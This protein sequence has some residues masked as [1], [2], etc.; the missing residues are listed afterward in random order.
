MTSSGVPQGDEKGL[1]QEGIWESAPSADSTSPASSRAGGAGTGITQRLTSTERVPGPGG[2][3][4]AD[5][6][7]RIMALILDIIALSL[8]GFLLSWLFGGLVSEPGAINEA[9]GQLDVAAFLL[10]LL[11]QLLVS[12]AYF[13]SLWTMAGATLGMRLLGLHIGDEADGHSISWRQSAIRWLI[14]GLP[15][16]LASTA[17]Y[18]PNTIGL[19][20][21]AVGVAWLLLLLY[22]MIQSPAKQGLHDRYAHTIVTRARRHAS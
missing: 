4:Y 11:L 2:L 5:V 18:V 22:T 14:L 15:A 9:G 7:N 13:G 6:P 10:V 21:G 12:F 16:L 20:L 19:I 3:L 17:V 8:I 1:E